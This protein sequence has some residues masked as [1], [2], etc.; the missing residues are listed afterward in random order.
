M[1]AWDRVKTNATNETVYNSRSVCS[2]AQC[3]NGKPNRSMLSYPIYSN[4]VVV[5]MSLSLVYMCFF[6]KCLYFFSQRLEQQM[7]K[8]KKCEQIK[9]LNT[10]SFP[11]V[12]NKCSQCA[13]D[14]KQRSIFCREKKTCID[15]G[16]G[17][18]YGNLRSRL[19]FLS[20]LSVFRHTNAKTKPIEHVAINIVVSIE[21]VN[22]FKDSVA[23]ASAN[24][25]SLK[26]RFHRIAE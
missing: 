22:A 2:M 10:Y 17:V 1:P 24:F 12:Q 7:T 8:R 18:R 13:C 6:L 23:A 9:R 15:S 20:S 4:N 3:T 16:R 11:H 26:I 5:L 25:L 19:N 21:I 14:R